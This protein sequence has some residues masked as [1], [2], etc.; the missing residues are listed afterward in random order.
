MAREPRTEGRLIRK[1]LLESERW[2]TL[3]DNADRL[4]YISLLLNSDDYGN[5]SGE[6]YRLMRMWRDFGITSTALV[7]KTLSEM[8]DHDMIGLYSIG[9]R[10]FIHL[11]RTFNTKQW[12]WRSFPKSPFPEDQDNPKKQRVSDLSIKPVLDRHKPGVG[13]KRRKPTPPVVIQPD[14]EMEP[15]IKKLETK[16]KTPA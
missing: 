16:W 3:K 7:A 12:W 11:H 6:P 13:V 8:Q 1:S 10:P 9:E 15:V 4:A 14:S 5:Y 2:L